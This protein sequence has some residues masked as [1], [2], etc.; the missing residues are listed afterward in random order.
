[1]GLERESNGH[2]SIGENQEN[3]MQE[4]LPKKNPH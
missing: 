4:H 2:M 1:M 3:I